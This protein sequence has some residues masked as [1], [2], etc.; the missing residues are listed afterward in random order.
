MPT[1]RRRTTALPG[2]LAAL[3]ALLT[4]LAVLAPTAAVA[5]PLDL[6]AYRNHV[7][8]CH[9]P[10]DTCNFDEVGYGYHAVALQAAGVT[11]GSAV[12]ADGITY[13]WPDV[14][15]GRPDNITLVDQVIPVE[16][17]DATRVG[18]LGAS[19]HGPV[20]AQVRLRYATTDAAGQPTTVDVAHPLTFADWTLNG[21]TASAPAGNTIAIET[22]FRAF[23]PAVMPT[24]TY[25]F[26]T[27]VPIDPAMELVAIVLP[28]EKRTRLFDIAL[29]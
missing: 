23:A 20:A 17:G 22:A 10:L 15:A 5:E 13:T 26:A 16:A 4:A 12:E 27:S 1:T 21:D 3:V 18:F 2:R 8:I 14:P 28:R 6:E 29:A 11:G 19:H 25:V 7:A 24:T 9:T